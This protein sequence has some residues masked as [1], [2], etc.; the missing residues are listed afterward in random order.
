[1]V[2]FSLSSLSIGVYVELFCMIKSAMITLEK[3]GK[4]MFKSLKM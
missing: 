2:I 3:Q 1:M 4:K